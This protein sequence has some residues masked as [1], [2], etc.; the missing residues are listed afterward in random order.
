MNA[1]AAPADLA[2]YLERVEHQ[3]ASLIPPGGA[4]LSEEHFLIWAMVAHVVRLFRGIRLLLNQGLAYEAGMLN[5][6]L[7]QTAGQLAYFM[8]NQE[9][10]EELRLRL[11][12]DSLAELER[13]A[14]FERELGLPLSEEALA[15][16]QRQRAGLTK[17]FADQGV[18]PGGLPD[19]RQM[20]KE[21]K[22]EER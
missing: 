9:R 17:A 5:R 4:N 16:T 8:H 18:N 19:P 6:T 2:K 1:Q 12:F 15:N 7:L 3:V 13:L 11:F 14:M 20:L 10:L 22:K 21:M